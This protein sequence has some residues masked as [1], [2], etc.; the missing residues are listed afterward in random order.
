[1]D[2]FYSIFST[3]NLG[4]KDIESHSIYDSIIMTFCPK[5]T[6]KAY[7]DIDLGQNRVKQCTA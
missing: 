6:I 1:M 5:L 2:F 3:V 7:V 4:G